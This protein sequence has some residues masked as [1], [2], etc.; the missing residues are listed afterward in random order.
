ME[1]LGLSSKQVQVSYY[2]VG[3]V[4]AYALWRLVN[5]SSGTGIDGAEDKPVVDEVDIREYY[6]FDVKECEEAKVPIQAIYQYP[7]RGVKGTR[8][9][10]IALTSS[11]PLNDRIFVVLSQINMKPLSCDNNSMLT[12]MRQEFL[13]DNDPLTAHS[14]R[15]Y[16][17]ET[18]LPPHLEK[19]KVKEL[20][21]KIELDPKAK[22]I[23]GNKGYRGYMVSHEANEWLSQVF[24]QRVVLL[25]AADGRRTEINHKR[26]QKSQDVDKRRAFITDAAV[27]V[28]NL[29]SLKSVREGLRE[30]YKDESSK[31][32]DIDTGVEVFRPT[33]VVDLDPFKEEELQELRIENTM[34]R[35]LGPCIRCKTTSLNWVKNMRNPEMEPYM[36]LTQKRWS[37]GLGPI[38]GIYI[39]PKLINSSQEFEALLPGFKKPDESR[40]FREGAGVVTAQDSFRVRKQHRWYQ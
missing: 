16:L 6:S 10:R 7:V 25:R 31:F 28:I 29:Q 15:I 8:V 35:Q 12:Y 27:H 21:L 32:E 24:D 2:L 23:I 30:K 36:Y 11:G 19:L 4:V 22:L 9:Q 34:L 13:P 33:F 1:T 20:V 3:I 37:K 5:P 39:Q 18:D 40:F 17:Q 26:L 38:L 14:V